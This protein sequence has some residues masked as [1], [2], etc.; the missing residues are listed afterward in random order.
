MFC[1]NC[2]KELKEGT[3][4]C[5]ECGEVLLSGAA[6][7][8]AQQPSQPDADN[9][10]RQP[11]MTAGNA[12]RGGYSYDPNTGTYTYRDNAGSDRHEYTEWT[13]PRQD[14]TAS[15]SYRQPSYQQGSYDAG[16]AQSGSYQQDPYRQPSYQQ[17]SYDA[18]SAQSGSYQQGGYQQGSYQQPAYTYDPNTGNYTYADGNNG[19]APNRTPYQ[20]DPGRGCAVASVVCGILSIVL[21]CLSPI[22]NAPLSVAAIICGVIGLKSSQRGMA[23]AGIV[24][25]IVGIVI[26]IFVGVMAMTMSNYDVNDLLQELDLTRIR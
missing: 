26:G 17:G 12:G 25:G 22:V 11:R 10:S 3:A 20:P 21:C 14:E 2:G 15:G 13:A 7:Q 8:D 9:A 19:Q 6:A 18:G 23:V 16:S 24:C 4:I 5:P 1:R